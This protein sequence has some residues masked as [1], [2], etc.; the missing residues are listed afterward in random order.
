M[1]KLKPYKHQLAALKKTALKEYAALFMDMGT[2]KTKVIIDTAVK[3]WSKGEINSVMVLCPNG[4]QQNWILREIPKH[5]PDHIPHVAAYYQTGMDKKERKQWDCLYKQTDEPLLRIAAVNHDQ[6]VHGYE[7]IARFV[8]FTDCLLVVDESHRIK[9]PKAKRTKAALKLAKHAKY[10]RIL[11]GTPTPQSP[12]D[13]FSQMRFLDPTILPYSSF[14]AFRSDYAIVQRIK[15]ESNRLGWF[16]KVTGYK[17][18]PRLRSYIDP[19]VFRAKLTECVDLPPTIIEQRDVKLTPTQRRIYRDLRDEAI[20]E[21]EDPPKGLS[22]EE[23]ILWALQADKIKSDNSL[24]RILRMMQ[25]TGGYVTDEDG[26]LHELPNERLKALLNDTE[27]LGEAKAIIWAQFIPEIKAIAQALRDKY[28][29][30]SVV[31]YYGK[32][33]GK[34]RTEA[35]DRFSDPDDPCRWFVGQPGAGGIGLTLVSATYVYWYSK[36]YNLEQL[37]QANARAM[38]IGQTK[39]VTYVH[40][41]AAGTLDPVIMKSLEQKQSIQQEILDE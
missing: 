3:L 19:H 21:I 34:E 4:L 1:Y 14:T 41:N 26:T 2:G 5:L 28:G 10:R 8:Q 31:E 20:A 27:D 22:P 15:T 36:S 17:N 7:N 9:T 40:F 33:K 16:D 24:T 23:I 13:L 29:D 12:L 18:L 38:R 11:S 6:L 30:D 32:V 25:A 35:V 37:L 39:K